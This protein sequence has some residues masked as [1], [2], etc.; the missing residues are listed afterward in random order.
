MTVAPS[1]GIAAFALIVCACSGDGNGDGDDPSTSGSSSSSTGAVTTSDGSSSGEASSGD[2][3][4]SSGIPEL[5][6]PECGP[7]SVCGQLCVDLSVDP[8]NCGKCGVSCVIPHASPAC[9][10]NACAIASCDPGWTDCDGDPQ[11]GCELLGPGENCTPVCKQGQPEACNLLDDNC[12]GQCDEGAVPGCRQPVHRASSPTLGHFYTLDQAEAA[13]GDF[14]PEFLN[15][16]YM[17]TAAQPGLVPLYR[18]LKGDGRRFYTTS[19]TCEGAG[20][21]EGTLGYLGTEAFC[22]AVPLYRLYGKA[23]HFYTTS[24]E[25]RDNAV[26]MYGYLFESQVGF[27]WPGP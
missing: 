23:D 25:E 13:S 21:V 6:P 17:H 9:S 18:C 4:S 19:D 12:D 20:P 2:A 16:F 27:V 3:S 1:H 10:G 22:G 7:L 11:N 14:K 24:V 15:Y 5:P 8:G 26:A